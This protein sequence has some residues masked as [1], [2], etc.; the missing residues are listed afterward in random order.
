MTKFAL[1]MFQVLR[2]QL[3]ASNAKT[4]GLHVCTKDIFPITV[5]SLV[6]KLE[7]ARGAMAPFSGAEWQEE[8][9]HC[10]KLL[11]LR[12]NSEVGK[13]AAET[14]LH[15]L[16]ASDPLSPSQLTELYEA[17]DASDL[18]PELKSEMMESVDS[19]QGASSTSRLV[20]KGTSF[21]HLSAYLNEA[22]WQRLKSGNTLDGQAVLVHRL[23]SLGVRSLKECTKKTCVA[24]LVH[25]HLQKGNTMPDAWTLYGL[26]NDISKCFANYKLQSQ[27]ATQAS[28][29]WNPLDLGE[30]KLQKVYGQDLPK[31][32]HIF[33]G[34][35]MHKIACRSTSSLLKPAT[36]QQALQ[37]PPCSQQAPVPTQPLQTTQPLQQTQLHT[38][39]L[40][41]LQAPAP[42]QPLAPAPAL[43]QQQQQHL[44]DFLR[45][46][47]F[48]GEFPWAQ[49]AQALQAPAASQQPGPS[50]SSQVFAFP[51]TTQQ[52]AA[53]A[54]SGCQ[55]ASA[56]S[57]GQAGSQAQALSATAEQQALQ[58]K[59][60]NP[61]QQQQ[62]LC[63]AAGSSAEGVPPAPS[64]EDLEA[65]A[66]ESLNK[67]GKKPKSKATA[68]AKGLAK[69]LMKKPAAAGC[70]TSYASRLA[71]YNK[72][73]GENRKCFGCCKCRGGPAGCAQCWNPLFQGQRFEG[74]A[75][76]ERWMAKKTKGTK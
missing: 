63:V 40:L 44:Q 4:A 33:L 15:R 76:Y 46:Q 2:L 45:R 64:L 47:G 66:F 71:A 29:P 31:G 18:P 60:G 32:E 58:W 35:V 51:S 34:P 13:A 56:A 50:S 19:M 65:Q 3:E 14:L 53:L 27:I 37:Q 7:I 61:E 17:L 36:P 59:P 57:A 73:T 26:V 74:R 41:P 67:S 28:Y 10:A 75:E 22:D 72:A 69:G 38:Q 5:F 1:C 9:Q 54:G 6:P 23:Q 49:P 21:A 24:L 11:K 43:S 8:L 25:L 52:S 55:A 30:E 39:P 12:P 42:V 70:C 48:N 16:H 62:Q 20:P 68:K